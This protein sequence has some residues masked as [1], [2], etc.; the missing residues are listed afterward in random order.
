MCYGLQNVLRNFNSN[1]WENFRF[2][3]WF[4]RSWLFDKTK[5]C[6]HRNTKIK[7]DRTTIK[8]FIRQLKYFIRQLK[9]IPNIYK[10]TQFMLNAPSKLINLIDNWMKSEMIWTFSDQF[11]GFYGQKIES[12]H[13]K[14]MRRYFC[15]RRNNIYI[16]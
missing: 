6:N 7:I 10:S 12:L 5:K 16:T 1:L 9:W 13:N 15:Y 4:N 8:E 3:V 2:Y 11:I 14:M